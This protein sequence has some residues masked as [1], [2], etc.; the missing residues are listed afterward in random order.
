MNE[1]LLQ[2][3][4][5]EE[6][7]ITAEKYMQCSQC[8]EILEKNGSITCGKCGCNLLLK[9]NDVDNCPLGKW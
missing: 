6:N 9:I 2:L 3:A 1:L 5:Y 4:R 7:A 8:S